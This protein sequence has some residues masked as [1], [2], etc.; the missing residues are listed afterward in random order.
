MIKFTILSI[1]LVC[2]FTSC[3]QK[4]DLSY[5]PVIEKC[6]KNNVNLAVNTFN[7]NRQKSYIGAKKNLYG[8]SVVKLITDDDVG[9]W[10]TDALKLEMENAGYTITDQSNNSGYEI[11]GKVLEAYATS[12]FTYKGK[13][14]VK[15][16]VKQDGKEIF[17]KNYRTKETNG[18]NWF[19][20]KA[21]CSKAL[22]LNLQKICKRFISDFEQLK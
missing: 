5:A 6:K 1:S 17:R 15:V 19:A 3:T 18:F 9:Q 21:S 7:D 14:V 20:R 12:H 22:T 13:M 16:I 8:I 10:V 11:E 4:I 2:L